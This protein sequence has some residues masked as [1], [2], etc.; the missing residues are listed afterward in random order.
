MTGGSLEAGGALIEVTI[1]TGMT[2]FPVLKAGF[3]VVGVV[4]S[5]RSIM[6]TASPPD[7][8]VSK[9]GF[10]FFGQGRQQGGESGVLES[11]SFLNKILSGG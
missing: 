7:F 1:N 2:E 6:V 3:M 10:F 11:G 9:G 8:C 5:E 4:M